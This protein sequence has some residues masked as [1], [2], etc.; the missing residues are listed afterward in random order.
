MRDE[1]G[2][3][4]RILREKVTDDLYLIRVDDKRVRFFE[5]AW[6]IPEGITY[7]AYL[8]HTG[9]GSVLFDGWKRE[10]AD[11]LLSSLES[12]VDLRDVKHA[13]VQHSEPDHSGSAPLLAEKASQVIFLGHP[14][15]GKILRS[16]YGVERFKPVKDGE[17]LRVG[18]RSLRFIHVPWLHW[19]DTIFTFI[20]EEGVL[21]SCD[22]FGSYSTPPAFDD[23]ADVR[24]LER[25][26]RKYAVTVVGHYS[27]WIAKGLEKLRAAGI[28]PR[29]IAPAHGTV[30]RSNP[31]WILQKWG[32]ISSGASKP[33]KVVLVYVSMYGNVDH[34]FKKLE[35]R[36]RGKGLEVVVH[37]FTDKQRALVSEVLA[38]A[39]DASL[40]V[41]GAPVYEASVHPLM[42]HVAGLIGEKLPNRK[43]TPVVIL[44]SYGWG[45]A[46]RKLQELLQSYGYTNLQVLDFEGAPSAEVLARVESLL[47]GA[48]EKGSQT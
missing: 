43:K 27:D 45:P 13:I 5:G 28:S 7:N 21:L 41:L 4:T 47:S 3:E 11:L 24:E 23:M 44:S 9:E 6:E 48:V 16:H 20:E 38:D 1:R 37:V 35:T 26:T 17:V 30:Y 39:S 10:Y 15:A 42:L 33:G 29:I 40:L 32:E 14:I 19:P 22:A 18:G 34:L 12:V 36:L 8:L 25:A 46:S 31:S 2:V